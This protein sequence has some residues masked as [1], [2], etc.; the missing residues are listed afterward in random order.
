MVP[1]AATLSSLSPFAPMV[2]WGIPYNE[3]TEEKKIWAW[4][5]DGFACYAAAPKSGQL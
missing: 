2:S 3:L 1:T 5:T 4:F